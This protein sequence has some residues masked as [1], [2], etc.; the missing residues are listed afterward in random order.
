MKHNVLYYFRN[1]YDK[2]RSIYAADQYI[3]K[4]EEY[5]PSEIIDDC[6]YESTFR[7]V[8]SLVK[9]AFRPDQFYSVINGSNLHL[10]GQDFMDW[11]IDRSKELTGMLSWNQVCQLQCNYSGWRLVKSMADI[12]EKTIRQMWYYTNEKQTE[13]FLKIIASNK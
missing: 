8:L 3:Q 10:L 12:P 5:V 2:N 9:E 4:L 1:K 6:I 13:E 11:L 7:Q